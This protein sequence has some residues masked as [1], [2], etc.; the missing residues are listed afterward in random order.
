VTRQRL[1][2]NHRRPQSTLGR[3]APVRSGA[4]GPRHRRPCG[5][6]NL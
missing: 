2:Y 1:G 3:P 4:R 5:R 6:S